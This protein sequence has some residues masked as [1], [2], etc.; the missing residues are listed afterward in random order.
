M[1]TAW[2]LS[3][4]QSRIRSLQLEINRVK[5]KEHPYPEPEIVFNALLEVVDSRQRVIDETVELYL[6]DPPPHKILQ[7]IFDSVVKDLANVAYYFSLVDRV[8]SARIPFEILRSLSWMANLL[9]HEDCRIVVRLDPSYNYTISSFRHI[10]EKLGWKREW[11]HAVP[12]DC[13]PKV[14]TVLVLGFP[15]ADASSILMHALAAHELGHEFIRPLWGRIEKVREDSLS[16]VRRNNQEALQDYLVERSRVTGV[17]DVIEAGEIT[18]RLDGQKDLVESVAH[19]RRA[20]SQGDAYE[21]SRKSF[22]VHLAKVVDNWLKELFADLVAARLVGPAFLAA[23]D[24]LVVG[25]TQPYRTHPPAGMRRRFVYDYLVRQLPETMQEPVWTEL[26]A[27]Y[28]SVETPSEFFWKICCEVCQ[29]SLDGLTEIVA[30]IASPLKESKELKSHI[31]DIQE[32]V[33]NLAP[34]SACHVHN[35]VV[36][37]PD[38]FWLLMFACWDFRLNRKRFGDFA[39]KFGW[40]ND[41]AEAEEAVGNLLLHSLRSLELQFRWSGGKPGRENR[42]GTQP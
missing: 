33:E 12:Q 22:E 3:C 20:A 30:S 13:D 16:R 28:G 36:S 21:A 42:N 17:S 24:R 1:P 5:N 27:P 29:F 41:L 40:S 39:E 11:A 19:S 15:S 9:L 18:G 32:Y 37:E 26:C 34:P 25:E 2:Q 7:P 14:T 10:F 4:L 35:D 6:P 38:R 31:Q 8:D 23:F